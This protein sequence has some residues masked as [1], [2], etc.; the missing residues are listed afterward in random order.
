LL[1]EEVK[2]ADTILIALPMYN[3]SVPSMLKAW[4]D[5]ISR[6]GTTFKYTAD[7]SVGLLEGKKVYFL[8]AM[9]GFHEAGGTDFLRPY[10]QQVMNFVGIT[11]VEIISAEGLNVSEGARANGIQVARNQIQEIVEKFEIELSGEAE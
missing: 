2:A 7:G 3:F 11:D 5:H 1:I 4:V 6:A 10:M 8:V 9:G